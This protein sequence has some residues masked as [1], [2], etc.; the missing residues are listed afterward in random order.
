MRCGRISFGW[1]TAQLRA[2]GRNNSS[3]AEIA[4]S[5]S[6]PGLD[7]DELRSGDSGSVD[8]ARSARAVPENPI[9]RIH[10][11]PPEDSGPT[12]PRRIAHAGMKLARAMAVGIATAG[13]P[14]Q[15]A[16]E[17]WSDVPQLMADG[18]QLFL[19]RIIQE[20]GQVEAQQVE[21]LTARRGI[22]KP[23][24]GP[25]SSPAQ[26][27]PKLRRQNATASGWPA[28]RS[29]RPV[30]PGKCEW[31]RGSCPRERIPRGVRRCRRTAYER[32]P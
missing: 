14:P 4:A 16:V 9:A 32:E 22:E 13:V 19:E 18:R 30:A 15:V 28:F 10:R 24:D 29:G 26:W 23:F 21:H 27:F 3:Y 6:N 7:G 11:V 2:A 25:T 8:S 17:G 31:P 5:S 12:S 20:A 1:M